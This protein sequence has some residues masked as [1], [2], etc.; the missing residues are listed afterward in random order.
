MSRLIARD[1]RHQRADEDLQR[2][3]EAGALNDPE[4]LAMAHATSATPVDD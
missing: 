3:I 2:L 4:A 1:A